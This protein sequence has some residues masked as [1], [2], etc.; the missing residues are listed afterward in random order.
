MP[1]AKMRDVLQMLCAAAGGEIGPHAA[2]QIM[3]ALPT[4]GSTAARSPAPDP[5]DRPVVR[6]VEAETGADGALIG[7]WQRQRRVP[8]VKR[9]L[10]PEKASARKSAPNVPETSRARSNRLCVP[11]V[12]AGTAGQGDVGSGL[13]GMP[14]I[15]HLARGL[16]R[17][18]AAGEAAKTAYSWARRL[19]RV[20][21]EFRA[22]AG[23]RGVLC[24]GVKAKRLIG[25]TEVVAPRRSAR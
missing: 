20:T 5:L 7:L 15:G 4:G 22:L 24:P 11:M 17:S 13:M 23:A 14:P 25:P 16:F 18:R 8:G 19:S 3:Q 6:E 1:L 2:L 9:Q 10:S 21:P 12:G